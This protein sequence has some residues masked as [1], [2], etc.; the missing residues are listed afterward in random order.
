MHKVHDK[1][2]ARE[3]IDKAA[4][5]DNYIM[6]IGWMYCQNQTNKTVLTKFV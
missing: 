2:A 6:S 3:H 1:I 4:A 5:M